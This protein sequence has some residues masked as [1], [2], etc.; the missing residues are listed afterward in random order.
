MWMFDV[1]CV[2]VLDEDGLDQTVVGCA[3]DTAA[4]TAAADEVAIE[5][6]ALGRVAE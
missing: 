1:C 4:A 3:L 5:D 2:V 6:G